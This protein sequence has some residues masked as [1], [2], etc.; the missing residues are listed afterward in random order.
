MPEM[1]IPKYSE[2][3]ILT[4]KSVDRFIFRASD[5]WAIDDHVASESRARLDRCHIYALCKRP[6]LSLVPNTLQFGTDR[7]SF[8]VECR[9]EGVPHKAGF[10]IGRE[11]FFP[12]EH[13][14]EVSAYPHR[15]LI[16]RDKDGQVIVETL[17]ATFA[18]LIPGLPEKAR[19]LEVMY[20][21][22]GLSQSAQDR[23]KS[24]ETLQRV[25][26]DINSHDPDAEVSSSRTHSRLARISQPFRTSPQK[27]Q[28]M[29]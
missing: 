20:I 6:R 14:F 25:L 26:G 13:A 9:V 18:H 28:A 24:H 11:A 29:Q 4:F 10:S 7:V 3:F 12:D 16:S 15:E 8:E 5:I 22:K 1:L 2:E 21:G 17:P 27:S 19:D 23:L